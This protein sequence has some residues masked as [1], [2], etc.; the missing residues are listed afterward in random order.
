M[1]AGLGTCCPELVHG[2]L[3]KLA[4][5]GSWGSLWL[6][7]RPM[8]QCQQDCPWVF[9]REAATRCMERCRRLKKNWMVCL[10]GATALAGSCC[11]LGLWVLFML[12]T[13]MCTCVPSQLHLGLLVEPAACL[14]DCS[15]CIMRHDCEVLEQWGGLACMNGVWAVLLVT[16]VLVSRVCCSCWKT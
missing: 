6:P 12:P 13:C 5:C 15:G 10:T 4:S 3:P 7:F 8:P 14:H 11:M 9:R 1:A 2:M 16:T